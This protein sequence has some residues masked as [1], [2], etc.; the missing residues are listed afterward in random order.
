MD[1]A[2]APAAIEFG[3]FRVLPRRRELVVEDRPLEL[4]GRAFDVL[5][6]LIEA[7]G[8]V[9]SKDVLMERVWPDRIVEENNLQAQISALRRALGADRDLIRTV[10]GRGYQFTGEIRT[11]SASANAQASA[12]MPQPRRTPP[13]PPANL[14]EP[15][16]E[17][18]GRDVE[19][20][21]I[22]DLSASHRLVTLTGAGGIGK[23]RLG[24]AAA[25]RLLPRFADGV[26]AIELAPLAD[27]ELVPVV[28]ATALGIE[29]ASGTASP[30]S[31]ATALRAKHLMLVLDNCEHVVEA[32]AQMAEA[33]LRANPATR[34]IATSREPLRAEGEWVYPVPPLAV[35]AEGS[36]DSEE[37]L[38]YGAVRLFVERA[39]AAAPHF[40]S[41]AR[42][43]AVIAGICRRLDGIP[44]AIE[45]AAARAAALGIDGLAARL[46]DRFRLLAGGYR[47][48]M[49]RHQTLRA[50]LDWSYEL[51]TEPERVVLCRLAI[52]A[53]GFTLEA[54]RAV[55]A[56]DEI[57][58]PEVVDRV[59][60]LVAK[61]LVT[62]EADGV[63]VRYRL[64]ET[65]RAYLLEKLIQA[66]EFDAAARRHA[67]RYRD[68]FE[69]GEAEAE[70]KPTDEWLAEYGPRID[71]VRAALDWAF[72]PGGDSSIG[73]ALTAASVPLWS[74]LSLM[75]ECRGRVE[76][77]LASVDPGSSRG[78][79]QKMQLYAALGASLMYTKGPVTETGA[80]WTYALGLAESLGDTT[81]QLTALWGLSFYRALRS[82]HR[83][84]LA[85]VQRFCT[86]AATRMHPEDTHVGERMMG[87]AL[88]YLGDQVHARHHIE[89]VLPVLDRIRLYRFQLNQAS[90]ARCILAH[91]LWL[92][93]FPEQAVRTS[94]SSVDGARASQ[95]ALSLC[96]AL[97]QAACPIA[98]FVGDLAAA[99]HWVTMLI[100][101][102]ER[103]ALAV[104]QILGR[105]LK[106]V[107]LIRREEGAAGL[108]LLQAALEEL[109]K[110]G[111][112]LRYTGFLSA[113]AEGLGGAGQV[114][115]GLIAVGDALARSERNDARW[116]MAELL[117]VK[118]ELL[119]LESAPNAAA[120]AEYHFRQALD[121]ACR[122]GALSWELRAA[123]SLARLWRDQGRPAD[124]MALLQP[125]Y[126]R[127]TEGFATADLK[128]AR[129]LLDHL[130]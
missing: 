40:S 101:H 67:E 26:Y 74:R 78:Q 25:W 5:M 130:R 13:R 8:A 36:P 71:N 15:V 41:D 111:Y 49:P 45:L 38:R 55:A 90:A 93:G 22:L 7:S 79:H 69:S 92:Q 29:L 83:S 9:V 30:L 80:A 76:R 85:L 59:P 109:R 99:E 48:T 46:D 51:L 21:E 66:G 91:V 3:R 127:F 110:T 62:V 77:A 95:H 116:N 81:F 119:L 64:L 31:V 121:W 4:G 1:L 12:G 118:G 120:A 82:E 63:R 89:R 94:Q 17:L 97:T 20:D 72:S 73:V 60:N 108:P 19:L 114:A 68:L 102:S 129:A 53:G 126:G 11:V 34:V 65:T 42:D 24:F 115:Q 87:A 6:V 61:S 10:A 35:P 23:T 58:A 98:L 106:G 86:L 70:T 52:F 37:P 14:P 104:W 39:R 33:L 122:Q 57:G 125:V 16:S 105:C 88:H 54:A 113:L 123:M 28:V 96:N 2:Q 47:T 50:T 18:I 32:A 100:D 75:E 112:V 117:R 84:E 27:P 43:V 107:L 128:A 124:A 103:H 56:D 44:L